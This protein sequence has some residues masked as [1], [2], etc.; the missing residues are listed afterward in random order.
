MA[1][2]AE[3]GGSLFLLVQ[4]GRLCRRF[5]SSDMNRTLIFSFAISALCLTPKAI[6]CIPFPP[7]VEKSDAIFLGYVTGERW[8]DLEEKYNPIAKTGLTTEALGYPVLLFRVVQTEQLKGTAPRVV[9]AISPC[10]L[11]IRAG[12]RVVVSHDGEKYWAYPADAP[13]GE[14][15][16]RKALGEQPH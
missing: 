6:G 9:E 3:R 1:L 4:G 14:Q 16:I 5:N 8:P 15:K 2:K 7:S 10:A 12:E 11:P 13:D